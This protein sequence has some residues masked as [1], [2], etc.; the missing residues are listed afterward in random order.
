MLGLGIGILVFVFNRMVNYIGLNYGIHP[1]VS[2]A[3]P[4]LIVAVIMASLLRRI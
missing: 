2:A 3:L 1:A 4:P